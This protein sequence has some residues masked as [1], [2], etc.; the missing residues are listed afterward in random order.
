MAAGE[1]IR[2]HGKNGAIYIGGPKGAPGAVKASLKSTWTV[3]RQ[4]DFVDGTVFG[5]TNKVWLAG[6][7]DCQGTWDGL[8]DNSGDPL[9]N[10]T[11]ADETLLYLYSDDRDSNEVLVGAGLAFV[12]SSING[13]NT[14]AIR[15]SG[16]FRAAG[17]WVFLDGD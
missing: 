16:N 3:N 11:D 1:G 6:L 7:G 13:S 10:L 15:S 9:V 8:F 12:D 2:K 5:D 14:D 4:R 17:S